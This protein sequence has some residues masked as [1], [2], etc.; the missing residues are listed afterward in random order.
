MMR[1][2]EVRARTNLKGSTTS[3]QCSTNF[4]GNWTTC[5]ERNELG[6]SLNETE[7]ANKSVRITSED[8]RTAR[9][10]ETILG[11]LGAVNFY[12][13]YVL[14]THNLTF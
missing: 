13:R 5:F 6:Q 10:V 14:Q 1:S 2:Q 12:T 9:D 3:P 4:V 7:R 8:V 11:C